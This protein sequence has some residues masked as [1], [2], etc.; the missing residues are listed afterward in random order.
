MSFRAMD[1]SVTVIAYEKAGKKYGM[2]CAWAM[3]VDY[4][5]LLLLLGAQSSTAKNIKKN[6]FIGVSTL[7]K[8]QKDLALRLGENH[9]DE[10]YKLSGIEKSQDD[11]AITINQA[12]RT[13]I[14]RV[15]DVYHLPKIEEDSL[16]YLE[17]V[18]KEEN[19]DNFLHMSDI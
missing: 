9:S 6:D 17:I 15:L 7:S 10:V 5:K 12:S 2:T 1:H 16:V 19:N 8:N 14:C 3:M 11:T 18:E 13:M 4:D